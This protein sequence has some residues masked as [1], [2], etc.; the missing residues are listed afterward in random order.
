MA[1]NRTVAASLFVLAATV[2]FAVASSPAAAQGNSE[3]LHRIQGIVLGPDD[4]P[5]EGI[6][7]RVFGTRDNYRARESEPTGTD[8]T[9]TI[10]V[11]DRAS[12]LFDLFLQLP[13]GQCQ[14]GKYGVDGERSSYEQATRIV[15]DGADVT[16]I[17]IRIPTPLPDLCRRIQGRVTDSEGEPLRL[18]V[19]AVGFGA[20]QGDTASTLS[21]A[22]G[23]FT[24]YARDGTYRLQLY[25]ATGNECAVSADIVVDGEDMASI[26]VVVSGPPSE[27]PA[28]FVCSSPTMAQHSIQGTVT[29]TEGEPVEGLL[30]SA[31]AHGGS[32]KSKGD[33][34]ASN[35]TFDLRILDGVYRLNVYSDRFTECTVSGYENPDPQRAAIFA[36]HGEDITNIHVTVA[37]SSSASPVWTGCYFEA[38][39]E[40]VTSELRPG[41]NLVGWTQAEADVETIFK[42]LPQLE[43]VYAWDAQEQRFRWAARGDYGLHEDLEMLT[44]GMGLWLYLGREEPVLWSRPVLAEAALVEAREGWNLVAWGGDDGIAAKD[45]FDGRAEPFPEVWGWDAQ[46]QRSIRYRPGSSPAVHPPREI[47]RGDALWIRSST[48]TRWLQPGWAQPEVV[49]L[50]DFDSDRQRRFRQQVATTQVLYAERYGTITSDVTFY[51][52]ANPVALADT[53]RRVRGK[54]PSDAFCADSSSKSI[55]ILASRCI[56]FSHEYFHAIQKYLS[57]DNYR[58]TP[59]WI[60]EGSAV[61][62]D[63]QHRYSEGQTS[64]EQAYTFLWSTLGIAL[65][66]WTE[67]STQGSRA[68]TVGYVAMEWLADES[69]EH[70][71]I[72]YFGAL[73]SA[74]D[75]ET[76]FERAFGLSVSEFYAMFEKY[77]IKVAPALEWNI[78]GTILDRNAQPMEGVTVFPVKVFDGQPYSYLFGLTASDG[79]F[80]ITDG[81]GSGFILLVR[82]HCPSAAYFG[83]QGED[84]FTT[85]WRNAPPFAGEDQDRTGIV[86]TLPTT[87][88]E[89]ERDRCGS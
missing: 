58:G 38:P 56:P 65:H 59:P 32:P 8:G 70:A 68:T 24:L 50:G 33:S 16:G 22:D 51:L 45:A 80:S 53:Y 77:R 75:W 83:A 19:G 69:S 64:Y 74:E 13:A 3:P 67:A 88:E 39:V 2:V 49:F 42:A 81:P 28:Q 84:G 63:F 66:A 37:P 46:Q 61:Y 60:Y 55:F 18:S 20:S 31:G 52:A 36:I 23:T 14:L 48:K 54:F 27:A 11:L 1:H 62:T 79:S 12:Y 4:A 73:K 29:D 43:V 10:T 6:T 78:Q 82:G 35:G 30:V 25:A 26:R 9:F 15:V 57:G 5:L 34:T 40:M 76:A 47:A 7:A 89:F 86:I 71:I 44:P 85:D 21:A 41:L 87:Q 17:I 72:D